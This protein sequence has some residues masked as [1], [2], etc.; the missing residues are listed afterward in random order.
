[1][2]ASEPDNPFSIRMTNRIGNLVTLE[3][4]RGGVR[5]LEMAMRAGTHTDPTFRFSSD[6]ATAALQQKMSHILSQANGHTAEFSLSEREFLDLS[7]VLCTV[8]MMDPEIYYPDMIDEFPS[9]CELDDFT[10]RVREVYARA[11][12]ADR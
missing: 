12:R 1:M 5:L 11:F 9:D 6:E 2:N 3:A 4:S 7:N 8:N 10:G